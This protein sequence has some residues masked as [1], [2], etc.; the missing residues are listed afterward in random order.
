LHVV[1]ELLN[2]FFKRSVI[3][4]KFLFTLNKRKK[5]YIDLCWK[6]LG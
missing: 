1:L 4:Y 3:P 5:F 2:L 6:R